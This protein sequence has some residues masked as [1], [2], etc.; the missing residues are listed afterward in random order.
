[1]RIKQATLC[2]RLGA[3]EQ[4]RGYFEDA[5]KYYEQSLAIRTELGDQPRKALALHQLGRMA[6]ERKEYAM[7][8]Q[9][10]LESLAIRE[11]IG[12]VAAHSLCNSAPVG[13]NGARPEGISQIHRVF[14]ASPGYLS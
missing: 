2:C 8:A 1:M 7:A 12:D 14:P 11:K 9:R 6:H 10:Y 13:P 3:V 5:E 4:E